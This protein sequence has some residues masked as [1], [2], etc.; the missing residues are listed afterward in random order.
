MYSCCLER[1]SNCQAFGLNDPKFFICFKC[2]CLNNEVGRSLAVMT[3]GLSPSWGLTIF[4]YARHVIMSVYL[5]VSRSLSYRLSLSLS[6]LTHSFFLPKSSFNFANAS[7]SFRI[8]FYVLPHL[9]FVC[10]E[11]SFCECRCSL[12][13]QLGDVEYR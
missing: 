11:G 8:C 1:W 9:F 3:P 5:S 12:E 10:F 6:F 2:I 13:M 4:T 7:Q